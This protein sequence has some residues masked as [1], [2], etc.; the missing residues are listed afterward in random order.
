MNP[1]K[2]AVFGIGGTI[3][4]IVALRLDPKDLKEVTIHGIDCL[5]EWAVTL[6]GNRIPIPLVKKGA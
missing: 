5:K 6:R 4:I 3:S 2:I 1:T